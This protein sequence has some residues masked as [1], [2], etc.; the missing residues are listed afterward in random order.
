MHGLEHARIVWEGDPA[1]FAQQAGGDLPMTARIWLLLAAALSACQAAPKG[2]GETGLPTYYALTPGA[3]AP[4]P[5]TT[6]L[7][8]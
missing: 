5:I 7:A 8:R 4:Q 3:G 2:P 6:D 1:R